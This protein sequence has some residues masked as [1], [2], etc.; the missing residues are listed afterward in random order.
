MEIRE[1][2]QIGI[3][4]VIVTVIFFVFITG[5]AET[6]GTDGADITIVPIIDE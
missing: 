5:M 1:D 4:F 2:T 6:E 3:L